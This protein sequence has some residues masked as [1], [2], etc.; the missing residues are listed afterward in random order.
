MKR[1]LLIFTM[2]ACC[3]Y[4]RADWNTDLSKNVQ[5][6]PVGVNYYEKD[7]TTNI[8]GV[9]YILLVCPS[10]D[11]G[12]AYRLQ[13]M[14]KDGN[15]TLGRGGKIISAKPNRTWTTWNQYLQTDN[16][17]NAFVGIQDHRIDDQNLNY[18]ISKYSE[19]GELLWEGTALNNSVG[20][21]IEAG[22]SMTATSDN[23]VVCAYCFTDTEGSK[24][25]V[26]V[27][28]LDKDGKSVWKKEVFNTAR[29]SNPY[30]FVLNAGEDKAF[31][32]WVDNGNI[33]ANIIDT[34]TGEMLL[35]KPKV[36]Y[37]NGFAS[38]KVMEVIDIKQGPDNGV[39][40]SVVD[41]N[42][43]GRLVYVKKDL[44]LGLDEE[45]AGVKLDE[46][47]NYDYASTA[48]AV[49][50]SADDN[51]LS[52][53]YK[54]FDKENKNRQAIYFQKLN[55]DGTPV[56][57]NGGKEYVPLQTDKQYSYFKVRDLGNGASAV[58][59][60]SYDN[61]TYEVDGQMTVFDKD[62]KA[63]EPKKFTTSGSNKV[64]LWVSEEIGNN[65]FITA[66]DEKQS[67]NYILYMQGVDAST[68]S[69]IVSVENDVMGN[70][71]EKF[72]SID[73]MQRQTAEK[74]I[75]IVRCK[76]GKTIKIA[77]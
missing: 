56:W 77:K 58:F 60:L 62:G 63:E 54:S 2:I 69:G 42:K 27:E 50:Y 24:D 52:C 45:T 21:P 64:E 8:N 28:K 30:P 70:S 43:Q 57:E 5:I 71:T 55:M 35:D 40:I 18:T 66:W 76:D 12:L 44:S 34:Q 19:S 22:L 14:D 11:S 9:T 6:T 68:T 39:F 31:V 3:M 33:D 17:G 49:A 26:H 23:G 1:F 15:K 65:N 74:G 48:P 20:H 72:Y 29:N 47:A 25:K 37:S 53:F 16:D 10:S 59:Y 7:I 51:T 61:Y 46:T 4:G 75:N 41:G 13:I 67:S 32:M 38:S 73:G 36:V